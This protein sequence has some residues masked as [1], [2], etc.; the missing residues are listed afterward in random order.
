MPLLKSQYSLHVNKLFVG[1]CRW[2]PI[3]HCN[4]ERIPCPDLSQFIG[5]YRDCRKHQSY[6]L[7]GWEGGACRVST[8]QMGSPETNTIAFP[9]SFGY[10]SNVALPLF[11]CGALFLLACDGWL[12]E[13]C[14]HHQGLG[15]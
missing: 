13:K 15:K 7:G 5:T 2:L 3:L 1:T 6:S 14:S 12:N 8:G 11:S 10:I 4:S 9:Y